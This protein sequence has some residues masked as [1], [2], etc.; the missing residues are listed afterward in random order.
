VLER[1]KV[2]KHWPNHN[3]VLASQPK[4][5]VGLVEP[6]RKDAKISFYMVYETQSY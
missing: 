4:T 2:L 3:D 6:V 5:V 1:K